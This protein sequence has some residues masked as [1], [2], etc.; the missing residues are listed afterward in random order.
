M[1]TQ[2]HE[3]GYK[4]SIRTTSPDCLSQQVRDECQSGCNHCIDTGFQ[5]V[6]EGGQAAAYIVRTKS[7]AINYGARQSL[8]SSR[9]SRIG[10]R[11]MNEQTVVMSR[12]ALY[13][14]F[15]C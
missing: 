12:S 9:Q 8:I 2:S 14:S 4:K 7:F 6:F 3:S 13:R 11:S 10:D 5:C 1:K 15:D